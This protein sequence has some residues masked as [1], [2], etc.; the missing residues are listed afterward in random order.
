[1][2]QSE[3]NDIFD[4]T[5]ERSRAVLCSK[6]QEYVGDTGDRLSNFKRA[7]HL[8]N[9]KVSTALGGMLAKHTISVFDMIARH[10]RGEEFTEEKWNEKITDHINYLILLQAVLAEERKNESAA[11]ADTGGP[12]YTCGDCRYIQKI[13]AIKKTAYRCSNMRSPNGIVTPETPACQYCEPCGKI[14]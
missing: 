6:A 9:E 5:I 7:A 12:S 11:H 13:N 8:Q 14:Q 2:N 1:M 10:E 3:I 4:S